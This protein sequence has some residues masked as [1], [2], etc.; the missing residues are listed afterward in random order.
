M[1]FKW[2]NKAKRHK[3]KIMVITDINL[4][5]SHCFLSMW[6]VSEV[7]IL[8]SSKTKGKFSRRKWTSNTLSNFW[9]FCLFYHNTSL[10]SKLLNKLAKNIPNLYTECDCLTGKWDYNED[11]NLRN[12]TVLILK[13]ETFSELVKYFHNAFCKHSKLCR[14]GKEL[15]M[16]YHLLH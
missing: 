6:C 16:I 2:H 12:N 3:V 13:D 9:H 4:S 1:S 11:F 15:L 10:E 14:K 5:K 8:E 7:A